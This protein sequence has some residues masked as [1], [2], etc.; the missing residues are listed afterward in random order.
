MGEGSVKKCLKL[1]LNLSRENLVQI[2]FQ[3]L[4][5][6][7][8]S[9]IGKFHD[10]IVN[11]MWK[12]GTERLSCLSKVVFMKSS[13][14][15]LPN[16]TVFASLMSLRRSEKQNKVFQTTFFKVFESLGRFMIFCFNHNQKRSSLLSLETVDELDNV[17]RNRIGLRI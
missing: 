3:K 8:A 11:C 4:W 12:F 17:L 15:Y 9:K 6:S 13:C 14:L 1:I 16:M 7:Y 5:K 2:G 10:F